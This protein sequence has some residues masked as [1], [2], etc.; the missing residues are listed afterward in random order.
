LDIPS[1]GNFVWICYGAITASAK[2][3]GSAREIIIGGGLVTIGK[4]ITPLE[5]HGSIGSLSIEVVLA[6]L[7]D[8]RDTGYATIANINF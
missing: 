2:P 5:L 4:G 6:L 1:V 3:G 7:T 8:Q